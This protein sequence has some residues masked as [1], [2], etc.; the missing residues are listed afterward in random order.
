MEGEAIVLEGRFNDKPGCWADGRLG[1]AGKVGSALSSLLGG[2]LKSPVAGW[3][4][5][6]GLAASDKDRDL[7]ERDSGSS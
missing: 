6:V 7:G 2:L 4:V 5:C 3:A 1:V